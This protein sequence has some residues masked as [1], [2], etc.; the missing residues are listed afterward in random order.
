[1]IFDKPR[2]T[3][4][5]LA[6]CYCAAVPLMLPELA[7]RPPPCCAC[8]TECPANGF[9]QKHFCKGFSDAL[10]IQ[11]IADKKGAPSPIP[12]SRTK[13]WAW[14]L[15]RPAALRWIC[16]TGWRGGG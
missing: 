13:T 2:L 8:Q 11:Q 3:K 5:V 16:A 9:F 6:D 1:M 12:M 7:A 4:A 14:A 10:K 15:P